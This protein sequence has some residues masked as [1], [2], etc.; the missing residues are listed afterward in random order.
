MKSEEDT[1]DHAGLVAIKLGGVVAD[2]TTSRGLVSAALA[3][4]AP[5][6]LEWDDSDRTLAR[7]QREGDD[8][9]TSPRVLAIEQT[10][11]AAKAIREAFAGRRQSLALGCDVELADADPRTAKFWVRRQR[12]DALIRD[13]GDQT[14][15][16]REMIAAR[17][18]VLG[19]LQAHFEPADRLQALRFVAGPAMALTWELG[20]WATPYA[21]KIP[22]EWVREGFLDAT[23]VNDRRDV[24]RLVSPST[25]TRIVLI[26]ADAWVG[27]SHVARLL[28]DALR[29]QR[30]NQPGLRDQS[31]DVRSTSF[32]SS[33]PYWPDPDD[34]FLNGTRPRVWIVDAVD[35]AERRGVSLEKLGQAVRAK[36]L[37]TLVFGRPDATLLEVDR[38]LGFVGETA[39][40]GGVERTRYRLLPL[41]QDQ[42]RRELSGIGEER[43]EGVLAAAA[44]FGTVALTFEEL[45]ELERARSEK[46]KPELGEIRASIARH[47]CTRLRV[48]EDPIATGNEEMFKAAQFLAA[49]AALANKRLFHFGELA[50]GFSVNDVVPEELRDAAFALRRTTALARVGRGWCLSAAHLEEDLAA[51]FLGEAI[52]AR[53]LRGHALRSL[54]T[55]GREPRP[56]LERVIDRV[57]E[58]LAAGSEGRRVLQD[59]LKPFEPGE[60]LQRFRRMIAEAEKS[61]TILWPTSRDQLAWLGAPGVHDSVGQL[62][63]GAQVES[64]RHLA[65]RVALANDWTDLAPAA[66]RLALSEAETPK[67]RDLAVSL[68]AEDVGELERLRPLFDR[69]PR[70]DS[71]R[72]RLEIRAHLVLRLLEAGKLSPLD[73]SRLCPDKD[74]FVTDS[75][76]MAVAEIAV[77]LD[78]TAA[79]VVLDELRRAVSKTMHEGVADELRNPAASVFLASPFDASGEDVDRLV[80]ILESP[81]AFDEIGNPRTW[82]EAQRRAVYCQMDQ[83]GKAS[84]LFDAAKDG[85]WLIE[86]ASTLN[87]LPEN[88]SAD[89][90][91]SV[92][93]LEERG[94]SELSNRGREI[95]RKEGAWDRLEE[96]RRSQRDGV[97]LRRQWEEIHRK[98]V[99]KAKKGALA[100]ETVV[101]TFLAERRD[102]SG[103]LHV[104]GDF[105]FGERVNAINVVGTLDDLSEQQRS[106]I[107]AATRGALEQATPLPVP[108]GNVFSSLL[109]HE[110]QAFLAAALWKRDWLDGSLVARWL[111]AALV[112]GS[113]AG[114]R[115][116]EL[117]E[118]CFAVDP[119]ETRHAVLEQM[120]KQAR[121]GYAWTWRVPRD[122][123]ADDQFK[124]DVIALVRPLTRGSDQESRAVGDL[125][126]ALLDSYETPS[127]PPEVRALLESLVVDSDEEVP[128]QAARA[129]FRRWPS[130][131][132]GRA[133]AAAET[134]E[135]A[136][137][138]FSPYHDPGIRHVDRRLPPSVLAQVVRHLLPPLVPVMP[139]S[140]EVRIRRFAMHDSLPLWRDNL[141][142]SCIE[143]WTEPGHAPDAELDATIEA[144]RRYDV[145]RAWLERLQARGR[146]EEALV[147]TSWPPPSADDVARILHGALAL[148]HEPSD[149]AAL[150][151]EI[152][153]QVEWDTAT[154]KLVYKDDEVTHR[155]ESSLQVLLRDALTAGLKDVRPSAGVIR[156][157]SERGTDEPDFVVMTTN[158]V[159]VLEVPIEVK[160]SDN[161]PR[162]GLEDQLGER[163]LGGAARTHGVFVVGWTGKP[164][165]DHLDAELNDARLRQAN[166]GRT[167][168]VV[169]KD[170]LPPQTS[171]RRRP[172]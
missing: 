108:E 30:L 63:V 73:A 44:S 23:A 161:K 53:R 3:A 16:R 152:L 154:I 86:H 162:E 65:L 15:C 156:E 122:L 18:F 33:A 129:W 83:L 66:A 7:L 165:G 6:P 166:L 12:L 54:L 29:D 84:F 119:A 43:V 80:F 130:E 135:K 48:G 42:A 99:E 143:R 105:F 89:L 9:T 96:K 120:R 21:E 139:A 62:L 59:A 109:F 115:I 160:W 134:L 100:I 158:H 10:L 57:R 13:A 64:V 155:P 5:E 91:A 97:R 87:R 145:Y 169:R 146:V 164:R 49:V 103:R 8:P 107:M 37:T 131:G 163:Y 92:L 39:A 121:Q 144:I 14:L 36:G 168:H 132:V 68:A 127:A 47:R 61:P 113:D 128:A 11:G 1:K 170:L 106:E 142:R 137:V 125:L 94:E 17:P 24:A 98:R 172:K 153:E 31:I 82:D 167:I 26:L 19:R 93:F 67:V 116:E 112:A 151:A 149:L 81:G 171:R 46:K 70:D 117:I 20:R 78:P 123:W 69:I 79:R 157:P 74:V 75:R 147:S 60:A 45:Q 71:D 51:I 114:S 140:A 148:V 126:D 110:G 124:A 111:P 85:A 35:E 2:R 41:D 77:R 133:I 27:K 102:P 136:R 38:V 101:D 90:F 32:E 4:F 141:V 76:S 150:V 52:N 138:I 58:M 88:V 34:E 25:A 40:S 56:E 50:P 159:P 118:R 95:L 55:D 22:P 28:R 104:L 72:D